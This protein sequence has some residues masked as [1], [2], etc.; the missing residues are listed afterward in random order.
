MVTTNKAAKDIKK[1]LDT[2]YTYLAVG[3][4]GTATDQTQESLQ[5]EVFRKIQAASTSL[6]DTKFKKEIIVNSA[7]SNGPTFKELAITKGNSMTIEDFDSITDWTA[8]GDCVSSVDTSVSLYTGGSSTK[9]AITD[10]T[11][12]STMTSTSPIGDL[13][14]YTGVT[15]GATTQ[16]W[17]TLYVYPSDTTQLN[18]TDAIKIRIG[19]SSSDY[20][21]AT[22]QASDL[23]SNT[24]NGILID[25][26]DGSNVTI[27]GTPNW[28]NISY[29]YYSVSTTG[30]CEVYFDNWIISGLI[31]CR[32][33]VPA[34]EKTN[35]KE[36]GYE[37][38]F[39]V[40][41][42]PGVII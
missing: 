28:E 18:A 39:E 24:W 23:T 13:S 4:D 34:I 36:V 14:D 42:T 6:T 8:D 38:D 32:V 33:V 35:L 25:M 31:L 1:W 27:T 40:I 7:E 19:S 16:G 17:M 12:T 2:R 26:E 21:E 29:R 22:I 5:Q 37:I 3:R 41:N 30:N 15:S 11:H 10:N 9:L 20:L